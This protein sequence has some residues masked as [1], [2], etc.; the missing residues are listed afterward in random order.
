MTRATTSDTAERQQD[1]ARTRNTL[2]QPQIVAGA[3]AG[4]R[5]RSTAVAV[6][7]SASLTSVSSRSR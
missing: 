3:Y 1:G 2:Q 4:A 5:M 6:R 7:A